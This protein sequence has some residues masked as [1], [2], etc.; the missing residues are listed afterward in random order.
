MFKRNKFLIGTMIFV[1]LVS[2]LAGCSKS[3]S[4]AG[5][6]NQDSYV[7][8]FGHVVRP[9]T[10]KGMAAD[11][12][13]ELIEERSGGKIKVEVY[14]D[15]QLGTDQE[16]TEQMQLGTIQMN[17][18]FTA[19]L[20]PFVP[21]FQVFD[22]PFIFPDTDIAY[23]AM[24][25]A[26]GEKLNEYLIAAGLRGLGY[27]DGGF[28]HFTNSVRPIE[29]PED[30][31]GLKMRASQ[32]PL[33][34][35]QFRALNAGGI[36]IPFAE[37]YTALQNKTVDGQE[38]PLSNIASRRFYEVQ[39]YLTLSNHGYLGYALVISND[40]YE[41]LP[42][43]LQQ[44]VEEVANEV[45]R[46]QWEKAAEEEQGYLKTLEE[47]GIQ[48]TELTPENKEA[49]IKATESVYEEFKQTSGG[50]ALLEIL[51]DIRGY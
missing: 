35:S 25:G 9:T 36:S 48:I 39:D 8:K 34:I 23:K 38:N 26:L 44:L 30:I 50:E 10:A 15:S 27:W 45:S 7:I 12:F 41:S 29:T 16:I 19:V 49:F 31:S 21:Q 40:F 5:N 3:E 24:N 43:D 46:W 13:A 37:L 17:A 32:S 33:L 6:N 20:A 18:P 4:S 42:V 11:R 28:K 51:Q 47:S 2:L 1:L 14:P 22:L